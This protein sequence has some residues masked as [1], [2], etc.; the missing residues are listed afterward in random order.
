M[1]I[2][3]KNII[4]FPLKNEANL[5]PTFQR[6]KEEYKLCTEDIDLLNIGCCF[7]LE[8]N[9]INRWRITM[10][11]PKNTPYEG[12]LFTLLAIFPDNYPINGPEIIF[13]NRIYHVNVCFD[14]SLGPLGHI[15]VANLNDWRIS[16]KVKDYPYYTMKQVLFDIFCLFYVQNIEYAFDDEMAKLYIYNRD[17]YEANARKWTELYASIL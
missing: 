3:G 13:I 12:G 8:N 14:D 6:L 11:G 9:Q 16:G 7:S 15:C 5:N 10:F 2:Y 1:K 4:P 17:Q